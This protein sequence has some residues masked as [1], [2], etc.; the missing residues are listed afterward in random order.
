MN[1]R[2]R[3]VTA[4][5]TLFFGAPMSYAQDNTKHN[6]EINYQIFNGR[7]SLGSVESSGN[8]TT[9]ISPNRVPDYN[10]AFGLSYAYTI[11]PRWA[12][13]TS[14]SYANFQSVRFGY[15]FDT[16]HTFA[17]AAG[18]IFSG[19]DAF[20]PSFEHSLFM[21][22]GPMWTI[23]DFYDLQIKTKVSIGVLANN[24]DA[25]DDL[26][27]FYTSS[28]GDFVRLIHGEFD[29]RHKS[30]LKG[31]GTA[32]LLGE[33]NIGHGGLYLS[34]S[35][36]YRMFFSSI[37]DDTSLLLVDGAGNE[38][39]FQFTSGLQQFGFQIGLGYRF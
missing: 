17:D 27:V 6:I 15:T 18:T 39:A 10:N 28:M 11:T 5:V 36:W 22:I 1:Q 8:G 14:L 2:L 20:S 38:S 37:T 12:I 19:Q 32:E 30:F 25:Q 34:G 21:D 3:L 29:I 33:L 16:P 26:Y 35:F 13:S 23:V 7:Y 4:L 9:L 31:F 24:L